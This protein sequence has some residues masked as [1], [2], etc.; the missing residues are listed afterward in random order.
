[1]ITEKEFD[2][3]WL[4]RAVRYDRTQPQ[5]LNRSIHLTVDPQYG[6]TFPGQVAALTAASLFGRLSKHVAFKVP[7]VP[8]A[9]ALPWAGLNLDEVVEE[10]LCLAHKFGRYEQ[11]PAH[12]NDLSV[13]VGA[14]GNGLIIHG[15]GWKSYCGS[16]PSPLGAASGFNPFGAAVAVISAAAALQMNPCANYFTPTISN[17]YSWEVGNSQLDGPE[18]TPDFE[19]GEV[20]VVGLGSVGSCTMHFLSL[21]TRSLMRCS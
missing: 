15:C 19:I 1:M 17:T 3:R 20:W 9:D 16:E 10:I 8:I 12:D 14:K 4:D 6:S 13:V 7:S 11:R 18:V 21:I 5:L 2:R